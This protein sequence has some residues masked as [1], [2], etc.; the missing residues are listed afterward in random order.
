MQN[1]E[2]LLLG[3]GAQMASAT[4]LHSYFDKFD[5]PAMGDSK[6]HLTSGAK[7]LNKIETQCLY[8]GDV[9]RRRSHLLPLRMNEL[10]SRYLIL[11]PARF[12]ER[13]FN[14][15]AIWAVRLTGDL[16]PNYARIKAAYGPVDEYCHE[17]FSATETLFVRFRRC[18]RP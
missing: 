18:P 3:F 5:D 1:D 15:L 8:H 6:E 7:F 11:P 4:W 14:R 9:F 2:T 12:F 10:T 16:T 17:R 13:H